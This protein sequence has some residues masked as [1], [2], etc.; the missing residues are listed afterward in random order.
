MIANSRSCRSRGFRRSPRTPFR[1]QRAP[2]GAAGSRRSAASGRT[3][4]ACQ[5]GGEAHLRRCCPERYGAAVFHQRRFV[6][7]VPP[8]EQPALVH[9][10]QR[11]DEHMGTADRQPAATQRSQKRVDDGVF[12][13]APQG[14]PASARRRF[15]NGIRLSSAD[16]T[17][18]RPGVSAWIFILGGI[19]GFGLFWGGWCGGGGY[20]GG[21]GRGGGG[22]G[23]FFEGLETGSYFL[24]HTA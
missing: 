7:A 24:R 3:G 18:V 23:V 15:R 22:R 6:G 9:R 1:L 13:F 12:G 5:R 20:W 10:V 14:R 2:G 4:L 19:G 8:A 17:S 21:D 16:L 11:I